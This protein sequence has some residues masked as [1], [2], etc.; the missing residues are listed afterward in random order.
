MMHVM[1]REIRGRTISQAW[2]RC[3]FLAC[4]AIVMELQT[5]WSLKKRQNTTAVF[6][7]S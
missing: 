6:G 5:G 4:A 7:P 1:L 2:R 3:R